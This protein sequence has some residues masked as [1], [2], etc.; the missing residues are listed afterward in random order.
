MKR[1]INIYIKLNLYSKCRGINMEKS[2]FDKIGD[3]IREQIYIYIETQ[4]E[5]YAPNPLS[6][7]EY[8]AKKL[9]M[10]KMTV[11]EHM[12]ID[13]IW[14]DYEFQKR[15]IQDKELREE[16][17]ILVF[18]NEGIKMFENLDY[19]GDKLKLKIKKCPKHPEYV[20][21]S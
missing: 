17:K 10:D 11:V 3:A 20:K 16:N 1:Y 21:Y 19:K 5:G 18:E 4:P 2:K 12:L 8:I 9:D 13:K 7:V 15:I 6:A 14:F